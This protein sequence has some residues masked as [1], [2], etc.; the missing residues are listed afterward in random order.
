MIL[1]VQRVFSIIGK[2]RSCEVIHSFASKENCLF[3]GC[4]LNN[5]LRKENVQSFGLLWLNR[6]VP[7]NKVEGRRQED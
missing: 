7:E 2:K 4:I 6:K 1:L 5:L 3:S